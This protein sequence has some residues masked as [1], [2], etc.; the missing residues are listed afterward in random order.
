MI[1]NFFRTTF[2]YIAR[3]KVFTFINITG[4]AI[5]LAASLLI[6]LWIQNELSYDRFH[7]N[8]ENIYRVE[9]DQNYSG[10]VYHVYVTPQPSGPVW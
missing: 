7:S 4:L 9:M 10:D 1:K 3:Q 8:A 5:G 6:L 2:R